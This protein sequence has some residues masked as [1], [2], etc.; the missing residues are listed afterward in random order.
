MLLFRVLSNEGGEFWAT[1]LAT[2]RGIGKYFLDHRDCSEEPTAD[3][4]ARIRVRCLN[5][6]SRSN[7]DGF[8]RGNNHWKRIDGMPLHRTSEFKSNRSRPQGLPMAVRAIGDRQQWSPISVTDPLVPVAPTP[9]QRQVSES[10]S[11]SV[12]SL[13]TMSRTLQQLV[14]RST[15]VG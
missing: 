14:Q 8:P 10:I 11:R 9:V 15:N 5:L 3:E 12:G 7:L 2:S 6:S 13:T 1:R 4:I